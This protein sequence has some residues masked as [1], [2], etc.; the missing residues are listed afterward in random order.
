MTARL[1]RR[2]LLAGAASLALGARSVAAIEDAGLRRFLAVSRALTGQEAL[3]PSVGARLRALLRRGPA[4]AAALDRLEGLHRDEL[5]DPARLAGLGLR[6]IAKEVVLGWYLGKVG[7]ED[8][9]AL[10]TYPDA[11]MW[12]AVM[13]VHNVPSF[14]G[15]LPGF[16]AGDPGG[17]ANPFVVGSAAP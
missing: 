14:C 4:Q 9:P 2:D 10:V 5:L 1:R 12:R 7:P 3:E 11:L 17:Y 6:E 15:G 13:D 8:D 16:W